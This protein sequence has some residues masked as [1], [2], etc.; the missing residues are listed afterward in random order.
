VLLVVLI[1]CSIDHRRW[2]GK[3]LQ[4]KAKTVVM[5]AALFVAF[6]FLVG[7]TYNPFLYFRF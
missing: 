4:G 2:L 3:V 7:G 6:A 5:V 1:V